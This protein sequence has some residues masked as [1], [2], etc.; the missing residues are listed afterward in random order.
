MSFHTIYISNLEM[1]MRE[2]YREKNPF[3]KRKFPSN[4]IDFKEQ[5]K[6]IIVSLY[7]VET[8]TIVANENIVKV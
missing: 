5:W 1:N 3:Y 6:L 7:G 2:I 8:P 4:A